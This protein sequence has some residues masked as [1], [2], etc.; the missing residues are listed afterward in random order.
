LPSIREPKG[1]SLA[2]APLVAISTLVCTLAIFHRTLDDL[3]LVVAANRDEF[4][5]RPATAPITLGH[6]PLVVGGRDLVAGGSWLA[7]NQ[8]GL[9]VGVLNRRTDAA[10]DPSRESRGT[11]CVDLARSSSARHAAELL[12]TVAPGRY[13]PFN[14]LVADRTSA[15]V[16]Q[17][18]ERSTN[19]QELEPGTHLLT[20][21]DLN[22]PTC[23]RISR[24]ARS[25]AAVAE[26]YAAERDPSALVSDLRTVLADHATVLD[27]RR[28]TDQ[29]CIH[30]PQYGTRS[31][32]ILLA[33]AGGRMRFF[34]ASG[35]PCRAAYR[36]VALPW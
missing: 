24:S 1:R 19:V 5:G 22:D 23:P 2:L 16:A 28:P 12:R 32:S 33:D 9:V 27:E 35:P 15:F 8:L 14:I 4:Y 7:V 31:S 6:D 34:H 11:L 36:R 20:N 18:R 10:P 21:L 17:N 25:F 26:R 29:L 13:N 3:P 30:T